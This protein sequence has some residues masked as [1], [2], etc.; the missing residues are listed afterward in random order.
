MEGFGD[1]SAVERV[2]HGDVYGAL[3]TRCQAERAALLD[4]LRSLSKSD[5]ER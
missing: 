3:R 2:R 1:A 4:E 5:K